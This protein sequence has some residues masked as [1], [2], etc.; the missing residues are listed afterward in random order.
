MAVGCAPGALRELTETIQRVCA[1][2]TGAGLFVDVE[3]SVGSWLVGCTPNFR[4]RT[5][6]GTCHSS[7]NPDLRKTKADG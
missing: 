2:C 7:R 6:S 5:P 1:I 3:Q 4:H